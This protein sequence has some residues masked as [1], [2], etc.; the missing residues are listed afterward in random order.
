MTFYNS[1]LSKVNVG[2]TV[3]ISTN[4]R[5]YRS[6]RAKL[7][8]CKV[9]KVTK[10]QITVDYNG[11][12][13]RFLKTTGD[14]FGYSDSWAGGKFIKVI[15]GGRDKDGVYQPS[16]LMTPEEAQAIIQKQEKEDYRLTLVA[17][18]NDT[19]WASYGTGVLEDVLKSLE[20]E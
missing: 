4:S 18:L 10:T 20:G 15:S 12:P 3:V 9:T 6:W 19:N 2:D 13:I 11:K 16:R 7:K 8:V 17:K 1:V 5:A 14:E